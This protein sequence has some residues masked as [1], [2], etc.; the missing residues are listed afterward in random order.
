MIIFFDPKAD[1]GFTP[2]QMVNKYK[3][4]CKKYISNMQNKTFIYDKI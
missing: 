4:E 2:T 1:E 3:W